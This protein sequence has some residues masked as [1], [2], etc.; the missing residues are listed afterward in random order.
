[1]WLSSALICA[2]LACIHAATPGTPPASVYKFPGNH[3]TPI[4]LTPAESRQVFSEIFGVAR[5]HKLGLIGQQAKVLEHLVRKK[6]HHLFR[7]DEAIEL[8]EAGALDRAQHGGL[9]SSPRCGVV[10]NIAGIVDAKHIFPEEKALYQ[11]PNSPRS[12]AYSDLLLR[13][14]DQAEILHQHRLESVYK[15]AQGGGLWLSPPLKYIHDH[16]RHG[17]SLPVFEQHFGKDIA[18]HFDMKVREDRGFIGEICALESFI[19]ALSRAPTPLSGQFAAGHLVGLEVL[20]I[21]YGPHSEKY[22]AGV[23]AM[24]QS[25]RQ[26]A[27]KIHELDPHQ[28]LYVSLL[29]PTHD[30]ASTS[31]KTLLKRWQ[32]NIDAFADTKTEEEATAGKHVAAGCFESQEA[33]EKATDKCSGHGKCKKL[34]SSGDDGKCFACACEPTVKKQ[35]SGQKTT[36]WAGAACNKTDV[37][38][39]FQIF[40]WFT[41]MMVA[42]L[43]WAVKMLASIEIG[44][45]VLGATGHIKGGSN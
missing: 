1:M 7:H 42:T 3:E 2:S 31:G 28:F 17:A 43:W 6:A 35:G 23:K 14:L 26:L 25:L 18:Q 36:E 32:Q 12:S 4:G 27:S 13:L 44:G 38:F 16:V 11:I 22:S 20:L 5:F 33:C 19:D 8:D 39:E 34:S 45:G 30:S 9:W 29:P 15:N 10:L 24:H 40:F 37:S 41:I 21:K